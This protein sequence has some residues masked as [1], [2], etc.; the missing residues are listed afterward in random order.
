MVNIEIATKSI[1]N[2]YEDL[3]YLI[4][5]EQINYPKKQIE[6]I[7]FIRSRLAF[8][9]IV[10]Q[11]TNIA[12]EL[13]YSVENPMLYFNETKLQRIVD[14]NISNAI[15]Y[16]ENSADVIVRIEENERKISVCFISQSALIQDIDSIFKAY[17]R[18]STRQ[19]GLGLGL[20]LVKRICDEEHVEVSVDSSK[21]RTAFCYYFTKEE[22][23]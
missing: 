13:V 1:H 3:S 11:K 14:N 4:K 9:D 15:K 10:A 17:Y 19:D 18:E 8:F 22:E 21:E 7:D 12:L 5:K 16:T 23:I 2:L 6:L 20:S